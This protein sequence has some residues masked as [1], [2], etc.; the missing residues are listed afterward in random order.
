MREADI[1]CGKSIGKREI[2]HDV[3]RVLNAKKHVRGEGIQLQGLIASLLHC[4]GPHYAPLLLLL[5]IPPS[6][7]R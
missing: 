5:S 1:L 2:A 3:E 7:R 4:Q 6:V